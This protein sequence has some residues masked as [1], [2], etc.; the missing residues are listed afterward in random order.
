[1]EESGRHRPELF[2]DSG[3]YYLKQS[4]NR[5]RESGAY[6]YTEVWSLYHEQVW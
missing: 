5:V 4:G 2:L 1:M 3:S 6:S